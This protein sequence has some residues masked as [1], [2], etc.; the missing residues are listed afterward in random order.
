MTVHATVI[1]VK[2]VRF[3]IFILKT[4]DSS[5]GLATSYE[6]DGRGSIPDRGKIC[7]FSKASKT[8]SGAHTASYPMGTGGYVFPWA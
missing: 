7:L 2:E 5:V 4:R 3:C 6:L 8:S 1:G